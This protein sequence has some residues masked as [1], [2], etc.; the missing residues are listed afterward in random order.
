MHIKYLR[1]KGNVIADALSRVT[2]VKSEHIDCSDSLSNIEK[3]PVHQITQKAPAS[4]ERL[5]E[6][7]EATEKDP[8]LKTL[9][10]TVHEG[11]PQTIKD[12]PHSIQSYWYFRDEITYEDGIIYKGT[13][14]I[15]PKS[16]RASTL[17]VLHMGHYAIDKMSLRAR[18]TVYWPVISKDIRSTYHHCHICAKFARTQQRET[19]QYIETLQT[20]WEQLGLDIFSLKKKNILSPGN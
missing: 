6:L 4:P 12:C 2:S 8:S 19:L 7:R 14:I 10:K 9:A 20:A 17:K 13:R 1:G 15:I 16:E 18:E 11:W 5:Q 3:I